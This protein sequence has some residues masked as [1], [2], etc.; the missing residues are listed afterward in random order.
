M[1]QSRGGTGASCVRPWMASSIFLAGSFR[2][3][4]ATFRGDR[5]S[6]PWTINSALLTPSYLL[7]L[8]QK[9]SRVPRDLTEIAKAKQVRTGILCQIKKQGLKIYPHDSKTRSCF[10]KKSSWKKSSWFFSKGFRFNL[11]V[12]L[13]ISRTNAGSQWNPV[14][15]VFHR[16]HRCRNKIICR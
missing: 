14:Y 9:L 8:F 16:I 13:S 15:K 12:R 6:D 5:R 4:W 7:A 3:G 11:K 10:R 1:Y 2:K